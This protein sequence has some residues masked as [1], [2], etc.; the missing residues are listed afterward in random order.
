MVGFLQSHAGLRF[1]LGVAEMA[2]YKLPNGHYLAQPRVLARTAMVERGVVVL[3]DDRIEVQSPSDATRPTGQLRTGLRI[4]ATISEEVM[5]S[6][7]EAKESGLGGRLQV[8]IQKI[9][10]AGVSEELTP[11]SIKLVGRA[12]DDLWPFAMIDPKYGTVWFDSMASKARAAGRQDEGLRLYHRLVDLLDDENLRREKLAPGT[13][14]GVRSLPL[15][16][17]LRKSDQWASAI[18]EYLRTVSAGAA[19]VP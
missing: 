7:L 14:S 11:T 5:F 13:K 6:Q 9:E 2:V 12:N 1:T 15:S 17:L 8:F 10:P 3:T 18:E 16:P 19:Q 4:P